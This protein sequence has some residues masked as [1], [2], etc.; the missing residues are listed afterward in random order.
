M[1]LWVEDWK[2]LHDIH[3]EFDSSKASAVIVGRN[4]TGKL[5]LIEALTI[6]FRDLD[7]G[8]QTPFGYKIEYLIRGSRVK[9]ENRPQRK[10]P[11]MIRLDGKRVSVPPTSG[12]IPRGKVSPRFC[13]RLLLGP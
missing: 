12:E 7:L 11:R 10:A 13:L 2:N 8:S 3:I 5:N 9:V 4:G 1:N 6:I